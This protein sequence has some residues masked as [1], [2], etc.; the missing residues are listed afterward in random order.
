MTTNFMGKDGFIWWMGVVESTE[1]PLKIGRCRVRCYSYHPKREA[2]PIVNKFQPV[3]TE[4]LPWATCLIPAN[5]H[6]FYGRPNTGDW[7]LGFFLDGEEAQEPIILGILPGKFNLEKTP[8]SIHSKGVYSFTKMKNDEF[9]YGNRN[10]II[11]TTNTLVHKDTFQIITLPQDDGEYLLSDRLD[12]VLNVLKDTIY[13]PDQTLALYHTNGAKIEITDY[14]NTNKKPVNITKVESLTGS[15]LE[16]KKEIL[17]D[18]G[19]IEDYTKITHSQS[20][21]VVELKTNIT[22]GNSVDNL[23]LSLAGASVQ[24]QRNL[25]GT[26]LNISHPAGASISMDAEGNIAINGLT[27]SINSELTTTTAMSVQSLTLPG[28]G[29]LAA[30]IAAMEAEIELAKTLPVA[31]P[32]PPPPPAPEPAPAP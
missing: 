4:H 29:D 20:G 17:N 2:P 31:A 21:G 14:A 19:D 5:F 18:S 6:N 9:P 22:G 16:H 15:K 25:L 3:P 11:N 23:S 26:T 13:R 32:P 1:D 8:F 30:K 7:V 12:A 28:I 27:V 24:I 10:Q